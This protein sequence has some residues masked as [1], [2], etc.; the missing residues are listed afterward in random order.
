MDRLGL[1]TTDGEH[2]DGEQEREQRWR[3][4]QRRQAASQIDALT[5]RFGEWYR[6]AWDGRSGLFWAE[7]DGDKLSGDSAAALALIIADHMALRRDRPPVRP[8]F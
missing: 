6:I 4:Y 5:L 7:R 3:D 1:V 8:A 2:P